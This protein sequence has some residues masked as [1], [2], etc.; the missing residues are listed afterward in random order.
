MTETLFR[1]WPEAIIRRSDVRALLFSSWWLRGDDA[2]GSRKLFLV[3]GDE[4]QAQY[5]CQG[6]INCIRAAQGVVCGQ[7]GQTAIHRNQ[8]QG[9]NVRNGGNSIVGRTGPARCQARIDKCDM[10]WTDNRPRLRRL[11]RETVSPLQ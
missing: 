6:H 3:E 7:L 9:R 4:R 2:R 1:L 11:K 10:L 5:G 8:S